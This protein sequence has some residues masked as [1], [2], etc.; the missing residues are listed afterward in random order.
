[1]PLID[2]YNE[3]ITEFQKQE[4][5]TKIKVLELYMDKSDAL[6]ASEIDFLK[7]EFPVL[8]GIF[9]I[10]VQH[11]NSFSQPFERLVINQDVCSGENRRI[12][13]VTQLR[14]PPIEI[15]HKIDYNRASLKGTCLMYAGNFGML[16]I[17]IEVKPQTGQLITRSKW[18]F[19]GKRN[20]KM[21][22]ICQDLNVALKNPDELFA[23][24]NEFQHCLDHMQPKCKEVVEKV[25]AFIVKAFTKKVNPAKKQ[26]Y[27]MSA[28]IADL[29]MNK[30]DDLVDAIYYPSVPND[31]SAMNIAIKPEVVDELFDLIEVTEDIVTSDPNSGARG[32]L[33]FGTGTC[34]NYDKDSLK[35]DWQNSP[36]PVETQLAKFICHH[37]IKLD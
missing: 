4:Y 15:A 6:S 7:R 16:P 32:W 33:A 35:L 10:R 14:Y 23:D 21:I 34:K 3:D 18:Q 25:A 1:M 5:L 28:L 36:I 8:I 27:I 11:F 24:Y 12:H 20:L 2:L 9:P 37:K 22:T 31:G 19:N 30:S 29:Y 26:G 17:T 13:S